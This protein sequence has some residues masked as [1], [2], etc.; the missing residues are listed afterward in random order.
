MAR[1]PDEGPTGLI[2]DRARRF[3][4]TEE[5]SVRS[6]LTEDNVLSALV[7]RTASAGECHF[8]ELIE[9]QLADPLGGALSGEP[10]QLGTTLD[11]SAAPGK[12]CQHLA[13]PE[14][15]ENDRRLAEG[16]SGF[17][18][19]PKRLTCVSQAELRPDPAGGPRPPPSRE[20]GTLPGLPTGP[21]ASLCWSGRRSRPP[22]LLPR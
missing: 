12:S 9:V 16:D 15:R 1:T 19:A 13:P 10:S 14:A 7:Q 6:P 8:P 20:P 17:E 18:V 2:L 4:D 21:G 5:P 11:L 3:A 22:D